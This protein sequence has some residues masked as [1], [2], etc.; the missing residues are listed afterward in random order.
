[1]VSDLIM[2]FN[3]SG[4]L[5]PLH[6]L[7][8]PRIIIPSIIVKGENIVYPVVVYRPNVYCR[9]TFANC[10][11]MSFGRQGIKVLYSTKTIVWY[12]TVEMTEF[13][14]Y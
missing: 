11:S 1:M 12:V 14:T 7:V 3:V 6:L 13:L 10:S 8:N 4:T 5:V 2:P 9:K